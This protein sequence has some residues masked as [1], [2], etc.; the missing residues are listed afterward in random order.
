MRINFKKVATNAITPTY[1]HH[2]DA[3]LDLYASKVTLNE[4]SGYIEYHTGIALE[5][6]DGYVGLVYPRSSISNKNL[7]LKNSVGIIDAGYR[8]EINLRF[9]E[10]GDKFDRYKIGDKIGQIMIIPRPKIILNEVAELSTTDRGATGFG[11]SG[12]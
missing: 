7:M 9:I 2:D 11:G 5:I 1:A 8:G 10:V 4:E 3:C 6:P 12:N